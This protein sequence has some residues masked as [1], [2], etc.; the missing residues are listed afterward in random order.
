MYS[1]ILYVYTRT[2]IYSIVCV[3]IKKKKE[4]KKKLNSDRPRSQTSRW[5]AREIKHVYACIYILCFSALP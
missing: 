3:E 2:Y 5:K 4:K 1:V